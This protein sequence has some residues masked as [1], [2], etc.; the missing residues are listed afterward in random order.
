MQVK[1]AYA[2]SSITR[3]GGASIGVAAWAVAASVKE[4]AA[5][6]TLEQAVLSTVRSA[7]FDQHNENKMQ[8]A[9][10]WSRPAR[11]VRPPRSVPM[12]TAGLAALPTRIG[13]APPSARSDG[14]RFSASVLPVTQAAL[15]IGATIL[16]G[17]VHAR[18]VT[19]QARGA[20]RRR[21]GPQA[22]SMPVCRRWDADFA[23]Y[24]EACPSTQAPVAAPFALGAADA[25]PGAKQC[26][27]SIETPKTLKAMSTACASV[28]RGPI[29][30]CAPGGSQEGA[31]TL[32]DFKDS[33]R[34]VL[35]V[36]KV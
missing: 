25:A 3:G 9:S 17:G 20:Q 22:C 27:D 35:D 5:I 8:A 33:L 12:C 14:G 26:A 36:V 15:E 19:S 16:A 1:F 30:R 28:R 13:R 21:A 18:K 6:V 7:P 32:H 29:A 11:P 10:R 24:G 4:T 23:Q 2:A 34:A 31:I